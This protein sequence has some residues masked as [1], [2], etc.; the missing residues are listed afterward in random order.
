MWLAL[1]GTG[2]I[3][4][5]GTGSTN[6]SPFYQDSEIKN[7]IIGD[8]IT[9]IGN[10]TFRGC[11]ALETVSIPSGVKSINDYAFAYCRNLVSADLPDGLE[12]IGNS[13]FYETGMKSIVIPDTVTELG[14]AAFSYCF[15]AKTLK[16]SSNLKEI[17]VGAFS[18]CEKLKTV[19][20]PDGVT[21]LVYAFGGCT[22][23][24][25]TTKNIYNQEELI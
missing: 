8:G 18:Y 7:I 3:P 9:G 6:K 16:I 15:N 4:D 23:L 1:Q 11:S 5:Y 25:K 13:A 19:E 17:P 12:Y 14:V 2:A 22:D 20:I 24:K 10:Y 21:K